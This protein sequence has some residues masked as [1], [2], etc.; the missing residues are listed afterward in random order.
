MHEIRVRRAMGPR[1]A[2][3]GGGVAATSLVYGLRDLVAGQLSISLFEMGRGVG[4]RAATRVTRDKPGLRVDH[5]VPAFEARSS[6][7]ISLCDSLAPHL[8]RVED[9]MVGVIGEV[10]GFQ[11]ESGSPARFMPTGTGMNVLTEALLRG[12][13]PTG[14]PLAT[15]VLGTMVSRV[16]A[17]PGGCWQLSSKK[18]DDLG[19]F[20]W[21]VVTSTGFAH[22]RWTSTF[23]GEPP[24]VEAARALEDGALDTTLSALAPLTSNPVTA[25]L[26][27][28]EGEAAAAWS[29]LPF[30]KAGVDGDAV[31]D[32]IIVQ[33]I[34]ADL[35]AVVFHS[36]HAFS[37]S[38]AKVYGA[39]STAARLAG[40]ATDAGAEEAVLDEML[41]AA[42]RWLVPR[43]FG[44]PSLVRTPAWGPHLHRWGAAFPGTP[45]LPPG[46]SLIPSARVAFAGDFIEAEYAG[47]VEGAALSGL[48]TAQ[49]L[50][51]LLFDGADPSTCNK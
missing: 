35:T 34:N 14:Q 41:K 15:T 21:L 36:T 29:A 8:S 51:E 2:V 12:G 24:L 6:E 9:G 45:L 26:V 19:E 47:S 28:Y 11:A 1:I 48:A 3:I 50:R 18:G 31:L 17:T 32:K 4:G 38:S 16:E 23:G 10:D 33:R 43:W 40:A 22:P 37:M 49:Q 20:D 7:F 25:C 30:V 39:T 27:A 46:L 5:G 44:K 42:E 13:D